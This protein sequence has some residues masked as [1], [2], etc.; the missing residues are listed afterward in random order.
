MWCV[1]QTIPHWCHCCLMIAVTK[2]G[3]GDSGGTFDWHD[4]ERV[5]NKGGASWA[6]AVATCAMVLMQGVVLFGVV[7]LCSRMALHFRRY[8]CLAESVDKLVGL[9]VGV[10]VGLQVGLLVGTLETLAGV[11]TWW[12]ILLLSLM[13]GVSTL[14]GACIFGT[15][16]MLWVASG[17]VVFAKLSGCEKIRPWIP[18]FLTHILCFCQERGVYKRYFWVSASLETCAPGGSYFAYSVFL[19]VTLACSMQSP[20]SL[21]FN[22]QQLY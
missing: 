5:L 13:R 4:L 18:A 12:V 22:L 8:S 19:G 21:F 15:C 9:F 10:L 2:P 1:R 20:E 6:A 7:G 17:V 14:R 3:W 16:C 11:S